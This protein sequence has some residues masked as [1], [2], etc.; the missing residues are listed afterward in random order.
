[1]KRV[2]KLI[3]SASLLLLITQKLLGVDLA[4][5]SIPD[6]LKENA[7]S[8][9]RFYN[10]T[11]ERSALGSYEE[12]VSYAITIL[13]PKGKSDATLDIYYDKN[14]TPTSIKGYQYNAAGKS[15]GKLKSSDI[16]D[17]AVY[18]GFSLFTDSRIK[19]FTPVMQQYPCTIE[20][21]Y[22][23]KH[24]GVVGMAPWVPQM[25][26]YVAIQK[27]Q[28]KYITKPDI[29][30][31]HKELNHDFAYAESMEDGL[32]CY[33]WTC[34][35]IK[36]QE[37][38][39]W[40]P[41][42]ADVFPCVLIAP[43]EIKFENT[44]GDF[45]NWLSY[46]K[47]VYSLIRET[48]DLPE[49]EVEYVRNLIRDTA[50]DREKIRLIYQYVQGR[51]RYVNISLGIGGF[52]PL[53]ASLVSE[54][55]YGDCKA[56]SNYTRLLLNAVGLEAYYAEIGSGDR[57]IKY[58][59]FASAN[60]T[61]HIIV[62]A[63]NKGDTIWLECTNQYTPCGFIGYGS[64]NRK[65]LLIKES[66]GELVNTPNINN[67]NNVRFS[68]SEIRL[69]ES[70]E[71]NYKTTYEYDNYM[72]SSVLGLLNI[73]PDEQKKFLYKKC[74]LNGIKI[75]NFKIENVTSSILKAQLELDG[76][77]TR[78]ATKLNDRLIIKPQYLFNN[79]PID[80]IK[81]DR[82]IDVSIP[83][84]SELV[85]TLVINLPEGYEYKGEEYSNSI[86]APIGE[87][88]LETKSL[89]DHSILLC[90]SLRLIGG[91]YAKFTFEEIN[92]FITKVKTEDRRSF[93]AQKV[94]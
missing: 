68:K 41:D 80:K 17:Y 71:A 69:T 45:T 72:Y 59:H 90:R 27:A 16:G 36:A 5:S 65:A 32:K 46:G 4:V 19:H 12:R 83:Y 30:F 81:S 88:H 64:V 33:T 74:Q 39:P 73:S 54:K 25:G 55:G 10:V 62:C 18:D 11:Y 66:G 47:W 2:F 13:K 85:D 1:M 24:N 38:Y 70:G 20:Y 48:E 51:T 26:Y 79:K 78:Y 53:N 3:F 43:R 6:S 76:E 75:S 34:Q 44:T 57:R 49:S 29:D 67:L 21:S 14:S 15:I 77:I 82:N 91:S 56:L 28:L 86:N 87:Y 42:F 22:T 92:S 52:K 60:Q 58:P 63:P 7:H 89:N 93:I 61:N 37:Y 50:T 9:V 94:E 35:N 8:V 40:T 84:T 31:K 23:I